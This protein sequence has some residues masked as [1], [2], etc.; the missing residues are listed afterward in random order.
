MLLKWA[1]Q[2]QQHPP[3]YSVVFFNCNDFAEE[4]LMEGMILGGE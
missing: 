3:H 2:Q 1:R 4:A